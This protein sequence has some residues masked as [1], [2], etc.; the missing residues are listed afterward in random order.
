MFRSAESSALERVRAFAEGVLVGARTR[1]A[2]RGEGRFAAKASA[3]AVI[4]RD[5]EIAQLGPGFVR[6]LALRSACAC[7]SW[8]L[9]PTGRQGWL[10]IAPSGKRAPV[11]R[12]RSSSGRPGWVCRRPSSSKPQ[13]LALPFGRGPSCQ[14]P[15]AALRT[16]LALRQIDSRKAGEGQTAQLARRVPGRTVARLLQSG[17]QRSRPPQGCPPSPSSDGAVQN[18]TAKE[19][20]SSN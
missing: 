11:F 10:V 16:S 13:A 4:K 9:A 6:E 17:D 3:P 8:P 20:A 2:G 12:C 14:G 7:G 1:S 15:A 5:P 19:S 18:G